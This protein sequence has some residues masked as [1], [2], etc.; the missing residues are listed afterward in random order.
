MLSPSTTDHCVILGSRM[1]YTLFV[2]GEP[3]PK[4]SKSLIPTKSGRYI[5]VEAADLNKG[6]SLKRWMKAVGD[7]CE[8]EI[9]KPMEGPIEVTMVFFMARGKT[10]KRPLPS[11][12]PD[13]D[14]LVRATL[15]GMQ[16]IAFEDDSRVCI[17]EVNEHYETE[18]PFGQGCLIRVGQIDIDEMAR[19]KK[20]RKKAYENPESLSEV[21]VGETVLCPVGAG[22]YFSRVRVAWHW[23][24]G[25]V[26]VR[27]L[28]LAGGSEHVTLDG[29]L[30][31]KAKFDGKFDT[32]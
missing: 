19:K 29:Q 14:K 26:C 20:R 7:V 15:D 31:V 9:R 21:A 22:G 8:R 5:M 32:G 24:D 16:S 6:K 10:V 27:P 1:T 2:G 30:R 28:Q 13:I 17:L 18:G 11:V 3:R 25:F 4:G 23:G 12:K